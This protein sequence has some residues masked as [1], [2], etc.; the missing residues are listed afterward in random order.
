M[1][2]MVMHRVNESMES[3]DKPSAEL[4]QRMGKLIGDGFASGQVLDGAGLKRTATRVRLTCRGGKCQTTRGPLTGAHE[5]IAGA[6]MI[7]VDS[8][9]DALTWAE[10]LAVALRDA[11]IDVGQVN[12]PWDIGVAPKPEGK[13][14]ERF[15]F[16]YKVGN[17]RESDARDA[18]R[19]AARDKILGE[20][21]EQ[22]ALIS[23]IAL[24]SSERAT[25]LRVKGDKRSVIDGPF[26]EAK[27]LIAGF[28]L[29]RVS[30]KD[31]L[32]DWAFRY[33]DI[34]EP[35]DVDLRLLEE[36]EDA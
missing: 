26:S 21:R 6:I 28:A 12:E 2:F 17:G 36:E 23:H 14:P 33:A 29:L 3:G 22:G 34:I 11:E 32:I 7:T 4:I 15:I 10:R 35:V 8:E 1:R 25:R 24:A 31:E 19:R 16:T 20:L 13:V 9:Q 30:S 18:K 5:P 27:E